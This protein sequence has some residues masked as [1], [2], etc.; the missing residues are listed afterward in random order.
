MSPFDP[1]SG[2][3]RDVPRRHDEDDLQR[4]VVQYLRWSLPSDATAWHIP[5]GGQRHSKAAARLVGLGLVAGMPDLELLYRGHSIF[6]ELKTKLGHASSVQRQ[7]HR[8]LQYCG[9]DVLVCRSLD[10]VETCLR[11]LGVPLKGHV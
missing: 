7:Q 6:L 11:E 4:A 1:D 3:W 8:K 5:N 2:L 9:A 10:A